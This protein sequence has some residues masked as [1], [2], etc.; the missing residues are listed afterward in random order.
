M[1]K[2]LWDARTKFRS[3]RSPSSALIM[4]SFFPQKWVVDWC[5]RAIR[6]KFLHTH[7]PLHRVMP[8]LLMD[9]LRNFCGSSFPY[10]RTKN[11]WTL[12][13]YLSCFQALYVI[14]TWNL[15]ACPSSLQPWSFH[16]LRLQPFVGVSVFLFP[17]VHASAGTRET[18]K[19]TR[20]M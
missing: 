4:K 19:N 7:N 18:G 13:S 9:E 16:P 3:P 1:L 11:K 2:G 20:R 15:L 6:A 17:N 12:R 8:C 10:F 5:A 14:L